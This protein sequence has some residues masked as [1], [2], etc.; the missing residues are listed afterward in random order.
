M[1]IVFAGTAGFAVP[2]LEA[3][4]ASHHEVAAVVTQPDRPSGRGRQPCQSPVKQCALEHGIPVLQPERIA[5]EESVRQIEHLGPVDV[6]VVVAYGQ[7][8]PR[9]LLEWPA[10]GVVNVHGSI[11]P[12]YR[13]AAPIQ[14][15]IMAGETRTG[16]TTMLMDGGWDTGDI[17]LQQEVPIQ[18]EE[19][20]G[21]LA[22]KLARVGA[23]LLIRTLDGLER[24]AIAP[25]PQDD[26]LATYA[27]SLDRRAGL[28]DWGAPADSIVNRVRGCT[29]QPGAFTR[30]DGT[31]L[32]IWR[33]SL[34]GSAAEEAR[35]GQ[36]LAVGDEGITVAA[37]TGSVLLT[38]VQPESRKRM[39]AA[40]Y[41]R[42][43]KLHAGEC[44]EVRIDMQP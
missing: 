12:K 14:H 17:L 39:P 22:E 37:G 38:D 27:P 41:A 26:S 5:D 18:P 7:K 9:R 35:P 4:I 16:V 33:A 29:P 44:F 23:E 36:I 30:Y 24:G 42:G 20:A 21:E 1:K 6:M 43:A 19:N 31:L 11:L 13:G 34:G 28:I 10:L 32:K 15:A 40:D 3:L 8:I 25:L 2:S